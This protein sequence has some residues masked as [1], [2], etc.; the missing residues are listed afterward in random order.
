MS[1]RFWRFGSVVLNKNSIKNEVGKEYFQ[2]STSFATILGNL[3][4]DSSTEANL[5]KPRHYQMWW[6][7]RWVDPTQYKANPW[8]TWWLKLVEMIN[9]ALIC[10]KTIGLV[11]LLILVLCLNKWM[12][13]SFISWNSLVSYFFSRKLFISSTFSNLL[14][15]GF[16]VF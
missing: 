7:V 4:E 2:L 12:G 3:E 16:I 6:I 8:A 9:M 15:K 1:W 10:V 14:V 5:L 11:C 13:L